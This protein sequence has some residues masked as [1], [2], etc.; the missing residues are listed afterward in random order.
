MTIRELAEKAGVS[1]TTIGRIKKQ[2]NITNKALS[3]KDVAAI[4][5][6][7]KKTSMFMKQAKQL[8]EKEIKPL[9]F[10]VRRIDQNDASSLLDLLQDCK[11]RYVENE[12]LIKRLSNEINQM[13]KLY[14]GN[15]NGTVQTIP[16]LAILDKYQNTNYRLRNQIAD[17]E[18]KLGKIT[19]NVEDNPFI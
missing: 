10:K 2:L 11:E 1:K 16:Q 19:A 4:L 6:E 18:E 14:T 17:L 15:K 5:K 8:A 12:F 9:K 3:K 13:D 7:A